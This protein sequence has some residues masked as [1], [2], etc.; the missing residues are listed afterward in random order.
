VVFA[1][2]IWLSLHLAAPA[3]VKRVRI[4]RS[5]STRELPYLINTERQPLKF[6]GQIGD[7]REQEFEVVGTESGLVIRPTESQ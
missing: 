2:G 3:A 4:P 6:R 1:G 5:T 7:E